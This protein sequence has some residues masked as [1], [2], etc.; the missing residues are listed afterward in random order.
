MARIS[1]DLQD[2]L[3]LG[4]LNAMRDWGHAK[5]YIEMQWLMLQQEEPDDFCIATGM[6]YSVRDF[7]NCAWSFLGK[8]IRWEGVGINEKGFDSET[9]DL[10]IS[11]DSAY[12]V[13]RLIQLIN[14]LCYKKYFSNDL[15]TLFVPIQVNLL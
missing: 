2:T 1:L 10:I 6:Q 3:Y 7:A 14:S 13:P 4:N 15:I 12:F 5:D 9:G 11:V 8:K